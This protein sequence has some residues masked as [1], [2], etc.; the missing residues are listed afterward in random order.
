[1]VSKTSREIIAKFAELVEG[2]RIESET[3]RTC[4]LSFTMGEKY[5]NGAAMIAGEPGTSSIPGLGMQAGSWNAIQMKLTVDRKSLQ[6]TGV[7]MKAGSA[8]TGATPAVATETE[9]TYTRVNRSFDIR[10]PADA[11]R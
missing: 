8:A 5:R 4:T 11:T 2:V 1:M 3:A 7:W 9:G 10:P 6:P